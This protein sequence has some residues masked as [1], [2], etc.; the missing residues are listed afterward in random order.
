MLLVKFSRNETPVGRLLSRRTGSK[1]SDPLELGHVSCPIP[2]ITARHLLF[3]TSYSRP[4]NSCLT[5]GLPCNFA[6]RSAGVSTF[7]VIDQLHRQLR[8]V[9]TPA[10]QQFRTGTLATHSLSACVNAGK[11]IFDLVIPVGRYIVTTRTTLRLF[12]P[13]C[14]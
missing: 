11:H 3:P 4:S 9:C 8:R 1:I 13:Y 7:H 5:V 12:S 2:A 6:W 14:L 10:A